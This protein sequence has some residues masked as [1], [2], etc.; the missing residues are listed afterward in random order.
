[1]SMSS[2][3]VIVVGHRNPDTDSVVSAIAF[4]YMLDKMG[5][6]AEARVAGSLSPET[7]AV[8][9]KTGLRPPEPISDVRARA[10]DVMTRDV[11]YARVGEPVKKAIDSIVERSIR[12]VPIV[13]ENM[14][15]IGLFSVEG[16]ARKMIEELSKEKL[17][18]KRVPLE[19]FLSIS[20]SKVLCGA[21]EHLEGEVI[22]ASSME[23]IANK[24]LSSAIIVSDN[25]SVIEKALEMG[26]PAGILCLPE[27]R[28]E[29]GECRGLV[30]QS[31]HDVFTTLRLLELSRPVERYA[32]EPVMVSGDEPVTSVKEIMTRRAVRTIVVVSEEGVLEGIITRSD[33]VRDYRRRVALVDHN[34]F[35][36]S[37]EGIEEAKIVAVVDHHR[38]GGD[39]KTMDP[40]IFRVEP[41]GSTCTVLWRMSLEDGIEIPGGIAEAMLYAI[42]SDTMLLKS[43]TTTSIDRRAVEDLSRKT[44]VGLEEAIEFI[45][46]A[47]TAGQPMDPRV[48]VERDYK[49]Y[50]IGNYRIGVSQV[51]TPNSRSYIPIIKRIINYMREYREKRKLN[52]LVLMITDFIDEKSII[53]AVGDK[54][55]IENAL[56]ADL[57]K[58]YCEIEKLV[59]RKKQLIP[60][61]MEFLEKTL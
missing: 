56:G 57:S 37:V 49:E 20:N 15:V 43:P 39:V 47:M 51:L 10:R 7:L 58:G 18:L 54:R 40:I 6:K 2:D 61:I 48:I 16:L 8:L 5:F 13:D 21:S 41:L 45:R 19:N 12:S 30:I 25:K 22:V 53:V 3:R 24:S 17:V 23:S 32:E 36:Q 14:R 31:P 29:L 44:G 9:E 4:A 59:S 50:V 42:L 34:E 38:I 33:L 60:R 27:P 35:S 26:A 46:I 11:V 1:M 52:T 28:V 55:I